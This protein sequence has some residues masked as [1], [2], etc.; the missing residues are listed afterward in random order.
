M[1]VDLVVW[2]ILF[3]LSS[4]CL[5]FIII[6][7]AGV[8]SAPRSLTNNNNNNVS[9]TQ[10]IACNYYFEIKIKPHNVIDLGLITIVL[11]VEMANVTSCIWKWWELWKL[12]RITGIANFN[13]ASLSSWHR[14]GQFSIMM[15]NKNNIIL[16]VVVLVIAIQDGD[17]AIN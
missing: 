4:I 7:I 12:T 6:I 3:K 1:D 8:A 16:S 15:E 11:H 9:T 5:Y 14:K 17:V 10:T 2:C 13:C